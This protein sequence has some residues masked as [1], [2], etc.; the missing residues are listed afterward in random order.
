MDYVKVTIEEQTNFKVELQTFEINQS[1]L[2]SEP[3]LRQTSP[4]DLPFQYN[5]D[6]LSI[7]QSANSNIQS[8]L[9]FAN[10]DGCF[11]VDYDN[12]INGDIAIVPSSVSSSSP[13]SS[14]PILS[15][16]SSLSLS[17]NIYYI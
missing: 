5:D 2:L 7:S 8:Y 4:S 6:F 17:V 1:T 13:P 10:N 9:F 12:I 14:P 15:S 11:P 16:S 3:V